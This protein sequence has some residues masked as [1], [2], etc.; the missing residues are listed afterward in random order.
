MTASYFVDSN[1]LVYARDLTDRDKQERAALWIETLA[2]VEAG[3]VSYQVLG[4]AYLALTHPRLSRMD[5]DAAR[6]YVAN[7]RH[8]RPLIVNSSVFEAAWAV[9]D[10]FN[11]NWWD[12]LIVAAARVAGCDYLLTEDLQHGQ[13]LNGVTVISPFEV[14]PDEDHP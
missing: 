7:F 10:H 3:R 6:L 4:E 8:W 1:V 2:I 9:Q 5:K 11:F 14:A 13:D 12:C